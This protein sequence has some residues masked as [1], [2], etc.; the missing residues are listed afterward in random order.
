MENNNFLGKQFTFKVPM[1]RVQHSAL[2]VAV[3]NGGS[4]GSMT[5][6]V[7]APEKLKADLS[8]IKSQTKNP[9]NIIF[10]TIT[11]LKQILNESK[12]G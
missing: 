6:S 2:A 11:N 10:F 1:A 5:C 8:L 9:F 7:R 4:L 3:S 12:I